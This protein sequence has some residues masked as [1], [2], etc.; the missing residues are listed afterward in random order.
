VSDRYRPD[1]TYATPGL[2][3]DG[4]G[5]CRGGASSFFPTPAQV[6][7]DTTLN[8][9]LKPEDRPRGMIFLGVPDD[10]TVT[11]EQDAWGRVLHYCDN[12]RK[13]GY[14]D[15]RH[16]ITVAGS[17]GGKSRAALLANLAT[18][19]GPVIVVDPKGDL[20]R[21]TA[22][23]RRS[24]YEQA[25]HILDPFGVTGA[26]QTA[27]WNPLDALRASNNIVADAGLIADA[28][29]ETEGERDPHW[30]E[31]ARQ[32]LEGVLLTVAFHPDFDDL[33]TLRSVRKAV[34]TAMATADAA[35]EQENGEGDG[36]AT[37]VSYVVLYDQMLSVPGEGGIAAAEAAIGFYEM[38]D[39]ERASVLSSCRRHLQFLQY[40][41]MAGVLDSTTPRL[42]LLR[43]KGTPATIYLTL[44]AMRMS[45]CRRWLRLFVNM[46]LTAME[47]DPT[48]PRHP[49]LLIL[50]EFAVLKHMKELEAAAG[51][52]AGLGVK[53]WVVLQDLTQLKALYKDRWETFLGNAGVLQ[54][55]ANNDLET[56]RWVSERCGQV[57]VTRASQSP[58]S[59]NAL[60]SGGAGQSFAQHAHA[61]LPVEEA[62]RVLDR[63]GPHQRQLVI[64]A[65]R[66]P[67]LMKR[68]NYDR[69][70]DFDNLRAIKSSSGAENDQSTDDRRGGFW[71]RR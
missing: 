48:V 31:S 62:A 46:T 44:P 21:D 69:C 63:D 28:L 19:P 2:T 20:A 65:G 36:D 14:A 67:I 33:R 58:T 1:P 53:L 5:Q 9:P 40:E 10:A 3:R 61:L 55:F 18:Y 60:D 68:I 6:R 17:R 27:S 16:V 57:E 70:P 15:D 49:V 13:L 50:D 59:R 22:A 52:I 11:E 42:D 51:Q 64:L 56:L 23:I 4:N 47:A 30:N 38:Q 25:T 41:P 37:P 54:F 43:L 39:K 29:V 45:T 34:A 12:G 32:F 8:F 26:E 66:D 7:D 35:P 24:K 71:R